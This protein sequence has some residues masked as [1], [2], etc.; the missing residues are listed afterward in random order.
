MK[1]DNYAL[2]RAILSIAA[3]VLCSLAIV[4][5]E[6]K[7]LDV[8]ETSD[9]DKAAKISLAVSGASAGITTDY[10]EEALA[11]AMLNSGGIP[12]VSNT[13][14]SGIT[15]RLIG[16]SSTFSGIEGDDD[17]PYLLDIRIIKIEAPSFS[18]HMEVSMN[19][20]WKLYDRTA[21]TTLLQQNIQSTYTGGAFEGGL[22]GANRVR[23]A[24]EGAA[25]ENVRV[26]VDLLASLDLE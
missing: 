12:T 14:S 11:E 8:S 7:T 18:V 26:G 20:V 24:L 25:R 9:A 6:A 5:V 21:E 22:L 2:Q 15:M 16:F 13:G 19:V 10:F 1:D 4:S 23:A 17:S 3:L